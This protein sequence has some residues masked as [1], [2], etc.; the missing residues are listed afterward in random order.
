MLL[1]L[2]WATVMLLDSATGQQPKATVS[3]DDVGKRITLI[4]RLG[5]P[6][7]TMI[8]VQGTWKYPRELIKDNSLRFEVTRVNGKELAK[9]V[10][11]NV[12]QI[13]AV[14]K[15]NENAI[16]PYEEH[17]RLEGVRWTM[18]AFETGRD[19]SIPLDYMKES[20]QGVGA[21]PYWFEPFTSELVGIVQE[22]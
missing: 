1:V 22:R 20:G 13:K 19:N 8:E 18:R 6:L 14:T 7:G 16:P 12:A 10:E 11:L 21:V 2:V 17:K 15:R 5:E 3:V 4:G 9:P